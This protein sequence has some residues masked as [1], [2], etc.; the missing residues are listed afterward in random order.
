MAYSDPLSIRFSLVLEMP[1]PYIA[2]LVFDRRHTSLAILSDNPDVKD[3]DDEIIGGICELFMLS[4][5]R[6]RCNGNGPARLTRLLASFATQVIE[7]FQ[8]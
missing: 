5:E 6:R 2:R 1:R 7:P 8:K 4:K 3:S